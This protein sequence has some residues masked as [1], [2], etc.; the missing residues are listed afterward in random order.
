MF[1]VAGWTPPSAT[2]SAASRNRAPRRGRC[3]S[4]KALS[5]RSRPCR[6]C[7]RVGCRAGRPCC[8]R[9][10]N[11]SSRS[12]SSGTSNDTGA[13]GGSKAV[14]MLLPAG[15]KRE[16]A[17]R[18]G[19]RRGGGGSG[20]F[21]PVILF[22]STSQ[23]RKHTAHAAFRRRSGI[24]NGSD[25]WLRPTHVWSWWWWWWCLPLASLRKK[26][27]RGRRGMRAGA[28][29]VPRPPAGFVPH[30]LYRRYDEVPP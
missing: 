11:S 9:S 28:A 7:F 16:G 4:R 13:A 12:S 19:F 22:S 29:L 21:R 27:K 5:S 17:R 8:C 3:R 18:G 24:F 23:L 26:H 15:G 10:C 6:R 20:H 1:R 2:C 30:M 25:A 14:A